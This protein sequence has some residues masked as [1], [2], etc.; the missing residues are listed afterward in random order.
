MEKLKEVFKYKGK[1]QAPISKFFED[2]LETRTCYYC[3]IHF[4][5]E[6]EFSE[7]INDENKNNKDKSRNEFTLDHYYDKGNYPYLALSL[8]N[9]IPSCYTCNSKLKKIERFEN[10]P[11]NSINFD[12]H[13]KIKFKLFLTK[14][15]KDLNVEKSKNLEIKL[16]DED[17]NKYKKYREIFRLDERYN[18][19]KDI[20]FEMIKK[21]EEYPD[22]RLKE[23]Q[24]LTGI[25]FQKI[26]K[27]IFN[28]IEEDED[29]SKKPFSKLIKD[30]S[31]EL[32]L[33]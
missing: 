13:E 8:Y 21:A 5:N 4:V 27:D 6:Y 10:L 11:P 2:N 9:L 29:L 26:K 12:F 16:K 31:E 25:P 19:H 22:S 1:F 24:E 18:A 15:C 23:L 32:G 33:I 28:L 30:M 17:E 7:D 3:N 14:D 20:V